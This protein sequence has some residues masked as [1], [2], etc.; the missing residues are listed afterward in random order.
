MVLG[1]E[2]YAIGRRP[3][4]QSTKNNSDKSLARP[5]ALVA[6]RK[7]ATSQSWSLEDPK[8]T[9]S[10]VYSE[11]V[12]LLSLFNPFPDFGIRVQLVELFQ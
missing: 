1:L 3:A 5:A 11:F 4:G 8:R 7:L 12:Q 6:W 9:N 10:L 2:T